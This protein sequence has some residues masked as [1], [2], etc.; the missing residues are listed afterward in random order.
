[1][2]QREPLPDLLP[3][4]LIDAPAGPAPLTFAFA[5]GAGAPMDTPFMG[6]FAERLA[7]R[8]WRVVRFEF[9]YMARRRSEA[10]R[11]PPDRQ[12]VLLETWQA[13]IAALGPAPLVIGGKSL[14]D[15][16]SAVSGTSVAARVDL[17]GRGIMKKKKKT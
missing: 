9:P 15:R 17:G 1:M 12:P 3:D 13:V 4:F 5:H 6:F 2:T 7:A 8:G 16:K 14:G 11:P 10:T